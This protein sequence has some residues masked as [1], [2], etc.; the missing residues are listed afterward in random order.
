MVSDYLFI[1]LYFFCRRR[2][3]KVSTTGSL[4]WWRVGNLLWVI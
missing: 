2:P 3:M 4:L 1:Y